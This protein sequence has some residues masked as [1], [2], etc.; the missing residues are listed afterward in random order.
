TTEIGHV[1]V[2]LP[3]MIVASVI[4]LALLL[5]S[6]SGAES[7]DRGLQSVGKLLALELVGL[8]AQALVFWG[9]FALAAMTAFGLGNSLGEAKSDLAG[10]AVFAL[11]VVIIIAISIARDLA[12]VNALA[13]RS[14]FVDSLV[15]A[16]RTLGGHGLP[17]VWGWLWRAVLGWLAIL[18]AGLLASRIGGKAG[19]SLLLLLI[20]HQAALAW[21][22]AW[23]ASWLAASL[24]FTHS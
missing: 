22:I 18:L 15:D 23:R 2:L 13:N 20:A 1:I 9:S 19:L 16:F 4:P 6:I 12:S 5:T 17:L 14:G 8:G 24:R 7:K 10:A 3:V 21:K 11:G